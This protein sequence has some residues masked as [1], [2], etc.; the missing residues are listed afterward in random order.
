MA[1]VDKRT[2]QEQPSSFQRQPYSCNLCG[3]VANLKRCGRCTEVYYCS[4]EHQQEDWKKHKKFCKKHSQNGTSNP[5]K[6]Q[7]N[8]TDDTK[9]TNGAHKLTGGNDKPSVPNTTNVTTEPVKGGTSTNPQPPLSKASSKP[10]K[11]RHFPRPSKYDASTI[12][13]HVYKHL[14]EDGHCVVD[15]LQPTEF[16]RSLAAE[17]KTLYQTGKFVDGQLGGGKTSSEDSQKLIEKRIRG[18]KIIMLEG[19]EPNVPNICKLNYFLASVVNE[20]N[21]LLQGQYSISGRTKI[22]VACYPG[23]GT[24]YACH[25]DNPNKD[26]RCITCLYYLN[27][28]WDVTKQGGLLRMYPESPDYVDIEPILNRVLFFWSDRRSP[29]E[30]QAAYDT[31]Y[32]V[33]IWYLDK[34]ERLKAKEAQTKQDKAKIELAMMN[35]RMK[36]EEKKDLEARQASEAKNAVENLTEEELQ[37]IAEMVKGRPDPRECLT[38]LGIAESIQS[39]LLQKLEKLIQPS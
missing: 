6:K 3:K 39:E 12:A 8:D 10:Y 1:Y 22:M 38:S 5:K 27:E 24:G 13:S 2:H 16:A 20:L 18:D 28:G 32:A 37:G 29:H 17:V 26:G 36:E 23:N 14:T 11:P 9:S 4:K 19:N 31:R 7:T 34:T 15:D 35:L 25:V 21:K 30:V 33:T